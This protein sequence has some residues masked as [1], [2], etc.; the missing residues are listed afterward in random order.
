MKLPVFTVIPALIAA[1]FSPSFMA[2]DTVEISFDSPDLDRWMYPFNSDP[3]GRGD[4]P[5]FGAVGIPGFDD[6]DGQMNIG[7]EVANQIAAG[8]GES[9]YQIISARLEIANVVT[10]SSDTFLYDP[11]FDSY[12]T[13]LESDDPEFTAD[14]DPGRPIEVFGT[15]FR[16]GITLETFAEDSPYFLGDPIGEEKRSA[17]ALSYVDNTSVDA[18]NS[19]A[20]RFDAIPFAIGQANVTPGNTVPADTNFTF[21][22]DLQNPDVVAYLQDAL[23]RGRLVLTIGNLHNAQQPLQ[24]G[25]PSFPRFY[26]KENPL[27]D[28]LDVEARLTMVVEISSNQTPATI[29]SIEILFGELLSGNVGNVTESDDSYVIARSQFGFLSSE[30][31]LLRTRVIATTAVSSPTE[32]DINIE[33]RLNNPNGN[34]TVR[35]RNVTDNSLDTIGE[36]V[37]TTADATYSIND[38]A[39]ATYVDATT[40][41]IEVDIKQVV[42]ATFSLSGFQ[43]RFDQIEI[44]V[45]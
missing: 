39:A 36:F 43:G 19:V 17:F 2:G 25:G 31:N 26:T 1:T 16:N 15:G 11:T 23:N 38:L 6:R 3:G 13:H 24:G 5:T 4:V 21:D 45:D 12:T 32:V 14:D 40:G 28:V 44:L 8:L 7:F 18:S 10:G 27:S 42:I 22:L 29:D 20:N 33:T 34:M 30:P 41:E 35:S 9:T 37:V